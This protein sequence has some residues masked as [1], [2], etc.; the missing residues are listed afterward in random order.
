MGWFLRTF[1]G[2]LIAILILGVGGY[3]AVQYVLAQLTAVPPKPTFPNDN[4]NYGKK[5]AKK[6]AKPPA[7]KKPKPLPAG[8]YKGKVKQPI[9]LIVRGAPSLRAGQLDGV[10]YNEPVIVLATSKDGRWE[11]IRYGSTDKEGWVKA[12]NTQKLR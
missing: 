6:T 9:G 2:L 5:V 10:E 4:P 7:A 8:A 3:F 12:G 1:T 11:K